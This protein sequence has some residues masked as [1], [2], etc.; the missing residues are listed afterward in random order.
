MPTWPLIQ[1]PEGGGGGSETGAGQVGGIEVSFG[2]GLLRPFRR[3]KKN[4]FASGSGVALVVSNVGQ[5][6]GTKADSARSSGELPWRTDFGSRMHLLRHRNNKD[7]LRDLCAVYAIE[8]LAKWE[9]RA[10]VTRVTVET[11]TKGTLVARVRFNV[12]D[13]RGR[14]LATNQEVLAPLQFE[15]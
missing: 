9:P 3:D 1:D 6:L 12:V 4:D 11:A 13:A 10:R 14:V 15:G 7:S 8:A 5:V 2:R